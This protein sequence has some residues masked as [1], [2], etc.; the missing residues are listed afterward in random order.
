MTAITGRDS[1][2]FARLAIVY[3]GVFAPMSAVAVR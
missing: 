3:I 1:P 2:G